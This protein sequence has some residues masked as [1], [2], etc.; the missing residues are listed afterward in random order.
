VNQFTSRGGWRFRKRLFKLDPR[1]PLGRRARIA[2]LGAVGQ[3]PEREHLKQILRRERDSLREDTLCWGQ[4]GY[5][6]TNTGNMRAVIE[7]LGDWRNR[8]GVE[9]W[10]LSNLVF[11]LRDQGRA[12]E[13]GEVSRFA[14]NLRGD[15]TTSQHHVLL[16]VDEAIEGN[17]P[18]AEHHLQHA[19]KDGTGQIECAARVLANA[20]VAVQ[21]APPEARKDAFRSQRGELQRDE[22]AGA[23]RSPL[24]RDAARKAV[25]VMAANAGEK[26]FKIARSSFWGSGRTHSNEP[27]GAARLLTYLGIILAI[28]IGRCV[29]SDT[30]HR[31]RPFIQTAA[32]AT[33][34]D[35]IAALVRRNSPREKSVTP[36]PKSDDLLLERRL[37]LR[38]DSDP[39]PTQDPLLPLPSQRLEKLQEKQSTPRSIPNSI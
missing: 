26:P 13:A 21:S 32:K 28:S 18:A 36:A 35:E 17:L 12:E 31:D 9:P 37:R 27:A 8:K 38:L 20:A 5:A 14:L 33:P 16:A 7:W 22:Y 25:A 24:L 23:F 1:S 34:N 30:V 4:A 11:A 3:K 39:Q 15:H 19:G 10:M 6:L 2:Y 29:S